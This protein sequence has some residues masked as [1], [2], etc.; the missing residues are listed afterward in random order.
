GGAR[1]LHPGSRVDLL[2]AVQRQ[3]VGIL[4]HQYMSQQARGCDA[5]V[6]DLSRHRC[7]GQ[8][9]ALAA[10]PLASDVLFNAEHIRS[11][12]KL[13]GDVLADALHQAAAAA[14]GGVWL[15]AYLDAWQLRRQCLTLGM[16]D[17]LLFRLRATQVDEFLLDGGDVR[18]DRIVQQ[19]ALLAAEPFAL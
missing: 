8:R 7:L 2:L 3:M 12:V 5:L 17:G 9:L 16:R 18:S 13:F 19:Q 1:D 14:S 6:D 15:V 4:R 10:R 11:V